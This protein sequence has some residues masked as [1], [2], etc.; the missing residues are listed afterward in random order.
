MTC[1]AHFQLG[2]IADSIRV[3]KMSGA[4]REPAKRVLRGC[5]LFH[6]SRFVPAS[7]L[8]C[9]DSSAANCQAP[10]FGSDLRVLSGWSAIRKLGDVGHRRQ[11]QTS[12][13]MG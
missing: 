8:A 10:F 12:A 1:G 9:A 7:R 6:V 13:V 2:P 5:S 3:A 11:V 4:A